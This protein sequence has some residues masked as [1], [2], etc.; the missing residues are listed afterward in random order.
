MD[1][2]RR[3]AGG[4]GG[5]GGDLELT[6]DEIRALLAAPLP[7]EHKENDGSG[8]AVAGIEIEAMAEDALAEAL[9]VELEA[10]ETVLRPFNVCDVKVIPFG[11]SASGRM[12]I[13]THKTPASKE[14]VDG[15]EGPEGDAV[16]PGD[17]GQDEGLAAAV[18][19]SGNQDGTRKKRGTGRRRTLRR[20]QSGN[21][22][23]A[24]S[25]AGSGASSGEYSLDGTRSVTPGSCLPHSLLLGF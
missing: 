8:E 19:G 22:G 3:K 4:G 13:F 24:D 12:T 21:G 16:A 1:G 9:T 10:G 6:E 7:R 11:R 5:G 18:V 2:S 23:G 25:G 14:A 17:E 15:R 20:R